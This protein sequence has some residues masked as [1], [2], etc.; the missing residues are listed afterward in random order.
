MNYDL[1]SMLECLLI[2]NVINCWLR[3]QQVEL[4]LTAQSDS[5]NVSIRVVEYWEKR[6]SV[7]QR[8]HLRA[9]ETLARV[10]KITRS[11]LQVNIAEEGSQQVNIA[12]DLVRNKSKTEIIEP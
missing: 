11:T 1:S 3:L 7:A 8:R 6:L 9:C 12:G 5:E 2:D 4:Q 10:R